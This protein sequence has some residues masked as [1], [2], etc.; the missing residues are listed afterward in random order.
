MKGWSLEVQQIPLQAECFSK[1][2]RC[3]PIMELRHIFMVYF[4]QKSF[5]FCKGVK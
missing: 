3:Q 4:V 1:S 2:E 5:L